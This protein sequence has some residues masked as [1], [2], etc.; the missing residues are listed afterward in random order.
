MDTDMG[1]SLHSTALRQWGLW[2][3]F[4]PL[5]LE[6]ISQPEGS[7]LVACT[8]PILSSHQRWILVVP[9]VFI[10]KGLAKV[11]KCL[12]STSTG[13]RRCWSARNKRAAAGP[14]CRQVY[15][16]FTLLF[17]VFKGLMPANPMPLCQQRRT[18]SAQG[19][20]WPETRE[21]KEERPPS[22]SLLMGAALGVA[23]QLFMAPLLARGPALAL[24]LPKW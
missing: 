1:T 10:W 20:H 7:C 19:R 6:V 2:Q 9:E 21:Q 13:L 22:P 17:S 12:D 4:K 24:M 5:C 15:F 14:L 3:V 23:G 16:S 8:L 11:A 18:S